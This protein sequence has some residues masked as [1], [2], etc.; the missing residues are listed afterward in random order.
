MDVGRVG[1][2]GCSA[3]RVRRVRAGPCSL[4][5]VMWAVPRWSTSE[6]RKLNIRKAKN[7]SLEEV[8]LARVAGLQDDRNANC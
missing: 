8:A 6:L 2:V 5:R 4:S 1:R 7:K 3:V